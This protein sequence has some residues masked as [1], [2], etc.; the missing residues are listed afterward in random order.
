MGFRMLVNELISK[1]RSDLHELPRCILEKD[2]A[3]KS[4][5]EVVLL[6]PGV[7]A[8]LFHRIGHFL[9]RLHFFFLARL[10]ATF[11]TWLTGIE[12]HPG[13]KIGRRVFIDHGLSTVIGETAFIGNDVT[14]YHGVTL[15]S[16]A[17]G[18]RGLR[19]PSLGDGVV[20]GCHS[21]ILGPLIVP[22]NSK[23]SSG[24]RLCSQSSKKEI[25]HEGRA[26]SL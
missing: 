9:Y 12:I 10:T 8:L 11:S 24:S 15:G 19:H 23:V 13:A 5:L 16:L 1:V 2:A 26:L 21:M 4:Y 6:Y 14:I 25:F 18:L 20:V 3:A 7:K 22:E 17:P